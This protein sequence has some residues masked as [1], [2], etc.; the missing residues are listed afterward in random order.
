[1][2]CV[3]IRKF[4]FAPLG[5]HS[6][7]FFRIIFG[8]LYQLEIS[9]EQLELSKVWSLPKMHLAYL[10]LATLVYQQGGSQKGQGEQEFPQSEALPHCC[11][12]P[13][14]DWWHLVQG[15]ME[16][17]H[18]ESRSAARPLCCPLILKSLAMPLY[19]RAKTLNS[20]WTSKITNQTGR[21]KWHV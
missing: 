19:I 11:P 14:N 6:H 5:H 10:V 15:S 21:K 16:S 18:F 12:P 3:W 13:P 2:P 7:Q 20:T 17:H 1:M 9:N 8:S 4:L